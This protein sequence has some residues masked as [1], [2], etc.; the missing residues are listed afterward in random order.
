MTKKG[1][2][3]NFRLIQITNLIKA[4]KE[5]QNL[6]NTLIKDF[7]TSKTPELSKFKGVMNQLYEFKAKR[8]LLFSALDS[9]YASL[10]IDVKNTQQDLTNQIVMLNVVENQLKNAEKKLQENKSAEVSA[11]RMAE[12]NT[13][14]SEKYKAH[15]YVMKVLIVF[16]I[17]I[18]AFVVLNKKKLIPN[19]VMQIAIAILVAFF[20]I[21]L[22]YTLFDLSYRNNMIYSEYDFPFDPNQIGEDTVLEFDEKQLGLLEDDTEDLTDFIDGKL[23]IEGDCCGAG[24]VWSSNLGTCVN[25]DDIADLQN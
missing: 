8:K 18:L 15:G 10:S 24:T 22:L 4:I 11:L 21:W 2:K 16:S 14:Y 17:L 25:H 7:R 20:I 1:N 19:V 3:D 5:L 9:A 6:D 13:Y 23:C 12:I